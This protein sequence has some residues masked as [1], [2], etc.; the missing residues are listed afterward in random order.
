MILWITAL[1]LLA[2]LGL[3]GYYQG[4][5]RVGISTVGLLISALLAVPL[6]GV[7]KFILPVVG[8]SHPA[9]VAVLAPVC[10]F[11][12]LLIIFKAVGM[13]VHKKVEW[14]YKNKAAD[15]K[16]MLF[17]RMNSRVGICMG[18]LNGAIYLVLIC[19][20]VYVIGYF[21]VPMAS[22]PRDS[23]VFKVINNLANGMQETKMDKAVAGF[24]PAKPFYYD[25]IDSL[26]MIFHT[27]LLQGR[28]SAYP[29][30]LGLS[31]R[32]EFKE[33]GQDL[34]FQEFWQS[35]PSLTEFR[36]HEKMGALVNNVELYTNVVGLVQG[37]AKDLKEYLATGHST[38]Y[39]EDKILG[40]WRIDFGPSLAAARKKK[41][42]MTR[43]ELQALNL[44]FSLF[45]EAELV[46][47]TDKNVTLKVAPP[48]GA[49]T[50]KGTWSGSGD[51]YTLSLGEGGKAE[52]IPVTVNGSKLVATK[53]GFSLTFS[54]D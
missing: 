48:T 36:E 32:Q 21:S 47:M 26:A 54:K 49:K 51:N 6:S 50:F 53:D 44:R 1:L 10:M 20:L 18:V 14:W 33:L 41:P 27:P 43:I 8:L 30:F 52:E 25:A 13:A 7:F 19:V 45:R 37:D 11:I 39:E 34:K 17:E 16:R 5:V 15:T 29:P 12:F 9:L 3:V 46:A 22:S 4:A 38:K 35:Q 2:M 24:V 40:R 31:E 23:V 28:L 42:N